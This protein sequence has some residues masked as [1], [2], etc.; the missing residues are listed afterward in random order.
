M[1]NSDVAGMGNRGREKEERIRAKVL[2]LWVP[3]WQVNYVSSHLR[4]GTAPSSEELSSP[5]HLPTGL[6]A[7]HLVTPRKL[8]KVVDKCQ[9][10]GVQIPALSCVALGYLA[11]LSCL[12]FSVSKMGTIKVPTT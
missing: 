8:H 12:S 4:R 3:S 5:L 11:H 9:V 1:Q 2:P 7:S 10:A 6:H